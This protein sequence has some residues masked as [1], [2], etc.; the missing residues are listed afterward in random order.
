ME[1]SIDYRYRTNG[2]GGPWYLIN[3]SIVEESTRRSQH[4]FVDKLPCI[5]L[6]NSIVVDF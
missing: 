6:L 5:G 3:V 2:V 1:R 4:I